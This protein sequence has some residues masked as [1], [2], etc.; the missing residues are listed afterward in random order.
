[1]KQFHGEGTQAWNEQMLPL[2]SSHLDAMVKRIRDFGFI[3]FFGEQRVGDA[4]LRRH[5]GVRSFDVG[6]AMLQCNFFEA[7]NLIMT[8][9]SNQ[10]YNPGPEE[11]NA[12]EV[13]KASRCAR[14]TLKVFPLN[15][16]TMVRERD[17]MKGLVRYDDPLAAI[18]CIPHNGRMFWVHAYQVRQKLPD[19]LTCSISIFHYI[20]MLKSHVWNRIA[21]ER[22]KRWGVRPVVGDLYINNKI[23]GWKKDT[24][25][26]DV[27]VVEDP[28][29]VDFS[30]I[31]LPVS[32][33]VCYIVFYLSIIFT[34]KK[35]QLPGYNIQYPLNEIGELY[36]EL[37]R[38]DGVELKKGNIPEA[39]AKGSYRKLIQK[40]NNLSWT[41]V[42][43]REAEALDLSNPVVSTA[44]FSFE[45][46]SGAYATMMLRE[47][48]ISTMARDNKVD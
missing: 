20:F 39:T 23:S 13:W 12:R 16:N 2:H 44:R 26:A 8:G 32:V 33:R 6:R 1:M 22:I 47:L 5:V 27:Q 19:W 3:N 46:E 43:E 41:I 45:L 11:I 4:G 7:I 29:S 24:D 42:P 34:W 15:K 48:M 17:L 18:R 10:V 21:T 31:V 30:C 25:N 40:A 38:A 37:L 9:R 36:K 28:S 35:Q 14:Q